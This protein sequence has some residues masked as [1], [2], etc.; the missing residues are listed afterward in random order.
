MPAPASTS[1]SAATSRVG[2]AAMTS[3]PAAGGQRAGQ[4]D[5]RAWAGVRPPI[6]KRVIATVAAKTA[7]ATLVS[8]ALGVQLVLGED[9]APALV[10]V[11][12][13]ERERAEDADQQQRASRRP[14]RRRLRRAGSDGALAAAAP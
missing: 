3:A 2:A 14:A 7:G 9:R 13:R 8:A 4:D 5:V 6:E 11:L 12:A 1:P 10:G